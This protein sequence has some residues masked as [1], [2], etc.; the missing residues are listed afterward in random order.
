M[1]SLKNKK[2]KRKTFFAS[3][4]RG[5][6]SSRQ[7]SGDR[8]RQITHNHFY[9]STKHNGDKY[10]PHTKAKQNRADLFSTDEI[11]ML[12]CRVKLGACKLSNCT[13]VKQYIV[14]F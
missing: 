12:Y 9:H 5:F 7:N 6:S 8:T 13:L 10:E 2:F 14:E 3:H 4:I 11:Q 1:E